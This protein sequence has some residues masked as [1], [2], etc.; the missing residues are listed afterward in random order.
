MTGSLYPSPRLI[1]VVIE[2]LDDAR[3]ALSDVAEDLD[4]FDHESAEYLREVKLQLAGVQDRIER[5]FD[6]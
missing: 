3:A 1:E 6:A 5:K 2:R 4:R